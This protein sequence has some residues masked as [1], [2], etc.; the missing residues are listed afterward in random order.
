MR[1]ELL[2]TFQALMNL[3]GEVILPASGY[4]MYPY[5]LPGDEC[6]FVPVRERIPVGAVGLAVSD[7]GILF[8]HRLHRIERISGE[9]WYWFRG[10][11]NFAPDW[12]VRSFQIVGV[13][14]GLKRRGKAIPENGAIRRLWSR[15]VVRVP[16]LLKPFAYMSRWKSANQGRDLTEG[17]GA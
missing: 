11:G 7:E 2:Q 14:T 15:L 8:S 17:S 6:R 16:K 9:D 3:K 1:D 12:P 10:D 5:I 4:S 13:L